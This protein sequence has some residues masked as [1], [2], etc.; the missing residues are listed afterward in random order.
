MDYGDY[1]NR[2]VFTLSLSGIKVIVHFGGY[3]NR[4]VSY[5]RIPII[6]IMAIGLI[7]FPII[8]PIFS[9]SLQNLGSSI[10]FYRES[11]W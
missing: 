7:E 4:K 11:R 2:V 5:R 10:Y 1:R 6:V 9:D 8:S 3:R